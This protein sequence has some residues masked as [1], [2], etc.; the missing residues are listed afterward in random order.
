MFKSPSGLC[1]FS[2]TKLLKKKKTDFLLQ[3]C[4]I[5]RVGVSPAVI[6]SGVRFQRSFSYPN[7]FSFFFFLIKNE[8][9]RTVPLLS[10]SPSWVPPA[11][12]AVELLVSVS[13]WLP[14]KLWAIATSPWLHLSSTGRER[15]L[16]KKAELRLS[17]KRQVTPE[18]MKKN[19]PVPGISESIFFPMQLLGKQHSELRRGASS[20]PVTPVRG[21]A[22]PDGE[23]KWAQSHLSGKLF[24]S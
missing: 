19:N 16:F 12:Q 24:F 18:S 14:L 10:S 15:L 11:K 5:T 9:S 1:T 8:H 21:A 17:Y 6:S 7:L 2:F 4:C 13:F 3:P 22:V 23:W 20:L